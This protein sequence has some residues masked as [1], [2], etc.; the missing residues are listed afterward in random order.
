MNWVDFE[1][2]EKMIALAIFFGFSILMVG[3]GFVAMHGSVATALDVPGSWIIPYVPRVSFVI[4]IAAVIV[5]RRD[6]NLWRRGVIFVALTVLFNTTIGYPTWIYNR[7]VHRINLPHEASEEF[8]SSFE[9]HF[10]VKTSCYSN[11]SEGDV[12][13]VSRDDFSP[14]MLSY[15]K[16][17][18]QDDGKP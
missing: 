16:Q 18:E 2:C 11:S 9:H 7:S 1:F 15:I 12:L 6:Q 5:I 13:A 17:T 4:Y 14:E 10:Q 3:G 8:Q